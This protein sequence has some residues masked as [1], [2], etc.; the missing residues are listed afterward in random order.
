MIAGRLAHSV[1]VGNQVPRY[2]GWKLFGNA[3]SVSLTLVGNQVPR[4]SGWKHVNI[5]HTS[6]IKRRLE[7][8]YRDIADGN[9]LR[10]FPDNASVMLETKYR[11]IADGNP[12]HSGVD[13]V[14]FT[15]LETKY[16]DIADGNLN[17]RRIPFRPPRLET[18]YRDI[19]DGNLAARSV[20][21]ALV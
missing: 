8:K 4:Y 7:T 14:R 9:H 17:R 1:A 2:S 3:H 13:G 11:D 12:L 20:V 15:M 10:E 16:R 19:A 6:V 21:A 18:K 5:R